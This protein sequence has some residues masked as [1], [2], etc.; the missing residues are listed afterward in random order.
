MKL[1]SR[2]L[3]VY[4]TCLQKNGVANSQKRRKRSTLFKARVGIY[5]MPDNEKNIQTVWNY[6][7]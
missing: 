3:V 5:R 7:S 2:Y 4:T 1:G 6:D